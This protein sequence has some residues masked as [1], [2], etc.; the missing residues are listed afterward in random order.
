[1]RIN[2]AKSA[3]LIKMTRVVYNRIRECYIFAKKPRGSKRRLLLSIPSILFRYNI[4]RLAISWRTIL[5]RLIVKPLV[6][7]GLNNS[8]G[9]CPALANLPLGKVRSGWRLLSGSLTTGSGTSAPFD[10]LGPWWQMGR[11]NA[12]QRTRNWSG[13]NYQGHGNSHLFEVCHINHAWVVDF[14]GPAYKGTTKRSLKA[15]SV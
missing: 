13:A 15:V 2:S 7:K 14:D 9:I 4:W 8:S 1:M 11:W 3:P 10:K 5:D 12:I 6:T